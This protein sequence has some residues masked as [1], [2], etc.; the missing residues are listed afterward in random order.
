MHRLLAARL[1]QEW[2]INAKYFDGDEREAFVAAVKANVTHGLPLTLADRQAAAIR[3]IEMQPH[4][5]DR[6]IAAMTGLAAGTVSAIRRRIGTDAQK[7]ERIGRDGRVRPLSSADSRRVASEIIAKRPDASLREV[8]K[9]AGTSP[10]TVLD[11]RRRIARG[12]DPVPT[13]LRPTRERSHRSR[14]SLSN[15]DAD[16]LPTRDPISL[17]QNLSK[18]PSLRLNTGGRKVL[19]WLYAHMAGLYGWKG[20]VHEIPTHSA[21]LIVEMARGCAHEWAVFAEH[22]EQRLL[23]SDEK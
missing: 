12:D 13:K 18:D 16:H 19:E 2:T 22:L 3:I 15:R 17:L 6:A 21:Y 8:A 14:K 23:G 5:S 4:A 7:R 20:L 9:L 1:R 11:V 10:A